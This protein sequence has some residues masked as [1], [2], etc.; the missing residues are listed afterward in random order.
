MGKDFYFEIDGYSVDVKT[1]ETSSAGVKAT[2]EN[3]D[4]MTVEEAV[5]I[6]ADR[7]GIPIDKIT[8]ISEEK[9][10]RDYADNEQDGDWN[11]T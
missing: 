2:I 3:G 1:G 4:G 9:Y 7:F 5:Q 6:I 8:V 10:I 11:E